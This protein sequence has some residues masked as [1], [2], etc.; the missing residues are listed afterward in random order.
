MIAPTL[1]LSLSPTAL[2]PL[3]RV[4]SLIATALPLS[5]YPTA[6][7]PLGMMRSRGV[8]TSPLSP[9][10]MALRQLGNVRSGI[11]PTSPS[12]AKQFQNRVGGMK[13]GILITVLSFGVDISILKMRK[14]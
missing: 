4:R 10:P 13:I 3:A 11:A 9:F 8:K 12:T 14:I 7:L 1:P 2:L 5:S 6:L